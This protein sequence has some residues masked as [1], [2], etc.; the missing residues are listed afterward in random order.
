VLEFLARGFLYKEIADSLNISMPT[1]N[2][3]IHRIYG[4]LHV[5]SRA[6]AVAKITHVPGI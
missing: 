2:T 3:H 1:V 6:E 5:R 4:K